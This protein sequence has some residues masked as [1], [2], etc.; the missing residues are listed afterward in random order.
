MAK[1]IELQKL[2]PKAYDGK[3]G[4]I[5]MNRPQDEPLADNENL[6]YWSKV[7]DLE[8]EMDHYVSLLIEKKRP[9]ELV[10]MERHVKSQEYFIPTEGECVMFFAPGKNP[11][12]PDEHPDPNEI[13]CFM[14]QCD[15]M[16]GYVIDR[17]TWHYPAFPLT[18]TAGQMIIMR[19]NLEHDDVELR[20]LPEPV[21]VNV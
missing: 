7:V 18:E 10:T 19:H 20:N 14:M 4:R 8:K 21:T 6:V 2:T 9:I 3:F 5:V 11:D 1:M 13:V 12:D 15:G 17:G 16:L